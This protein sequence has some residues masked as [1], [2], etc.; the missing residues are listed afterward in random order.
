MQTEETKEKKEG[1]R[2]AKIE[3]G[4][5]VDRISPG[6]ALKVLEILGILSNISAKVSFVMN[7]PSLKL[8]GGKKDIVKIEKR[9]LTENETD[10]IAIISPHA[11]INIIRDYKVVEKYQVSLP[12]EIIGIVKCSRTTCITN[13]PKEAGGR[14]NKI[15]RDR[16]RSGHTGMPPLRDANK[17]R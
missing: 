9:E 13:N 4:T 2:I 17:R 1:R 11:T 7:I 12:D 15:R 14:R 3:K 5:V 8:E 10:K 6:H 16:T